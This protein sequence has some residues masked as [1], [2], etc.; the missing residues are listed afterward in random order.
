MAPKLR[1]LVDTTKDWASERSYIRED[2]ALWSLDKLHELTA[3][4]AN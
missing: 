3:Q 2:K 1:T 4:A